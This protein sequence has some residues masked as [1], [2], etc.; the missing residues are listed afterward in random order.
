MTMAE[1]FSGF[2]TLSLLLLIAGIVLLILEMFQPGFG[3]MGGIGIAL[4]IL[5]VIVSAK[6]FLHGLILGGV[7]LLILLIFFFL[8]LW[9]GSK[10]KL[11]RKMI[12]LSEQGQDAG[13]VVADFD[14]YLDATGTAVSPLRPAGIMRVENENLNV[15]SDGEFIEAGAK[16]VIKKIEGNRLVVERIS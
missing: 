3:V 10:G 7:L 9:L 1:V 2:S 14:R 4:L 15:V 13:Y 6:S 8:F 16:L 11:P 12:L 5:D